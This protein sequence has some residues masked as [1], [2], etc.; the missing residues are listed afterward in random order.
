MA[1]DEDTYVETRLREAV[2]IWLTTVRADG[3]PQTSPVWFLW[4]GER[5]LIY[6]RP[7]SGKVPNIRG[8]ARVSLNLDGDRDGG[9][10]VTI[11]G[12]AQID[13]Q[14]PLADE[15]LDYVEKYREHIRRLGSEP[16]PFARTYSTPIRITPTR[17]RVYR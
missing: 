3:Q 15:V 16:E 14:A 11:E 1:D 5:F 12:T 7:R 6:S 2:V 9:E 10:I 13:E 8:N 4:D 17:R